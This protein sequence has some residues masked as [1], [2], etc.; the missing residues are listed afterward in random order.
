MAGLAIAIAAAANF[1]ALCLSLFWRNYT[2]EGV[3]ASIVTGCLSSIVLISL[4]PTIQ[5][6]ILGGASAYFPLRNPGIVAIPLSFLV[7]IVV[8]LLTTDRTASANF[9]ES[10]LV[11]AGLKRRR[12][13]EVP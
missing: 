7:G 11:L 4:S 13:S 8:S 12:P 9:D 6:D 5:V 10:Q 1:P 2:T 3:V